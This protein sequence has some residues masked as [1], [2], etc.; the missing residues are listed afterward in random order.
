MTA[1][2]DDA[3]VNALLR[4]DSNRRQRGDKMAVDFSDPC[5]R[6]AALRDAYYNLISGANESLIRYK[7]PNGEQE[8]RFGP[9]SRRAEDRNGKR[10]KRLRVANGAANP[11]R[12]YAIRAGARRRRGPSTSGRSRLGFSPLEIRPAP[13]DARLTR[14]SVNA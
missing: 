13:D 3:T 11:N 4:D 5:Q 7:G 8:V 6:F 12:R 2:V 1:E 10:G 14:F 9:A